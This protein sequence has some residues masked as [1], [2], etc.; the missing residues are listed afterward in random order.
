MPEVPTLRSGRYDLNFEVAALARVPPW[1][2]IVPGLANPSQGGLVSIIRG[3]FLFLFGFLLVSILR[4][5]ALLGTAAYILGVNRVG[6]KGCNQC[7][8][9]NSHS[10]I[11]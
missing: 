2:V 3:V 8:R 4:R 6:R 10:G 7:C 1:I 9:K 5:I 11:S